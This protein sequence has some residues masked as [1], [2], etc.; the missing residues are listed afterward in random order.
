[1]KMATGMEVGNWQLHHNNTHTHASRLVQG[2]VCVCVCVCETSND[3][4][5]PGPLQPKFGAPSLL[6][7]LKTKITY[8][9]E[10]IS[11]C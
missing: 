10:E 6:A 5:D 7:F 9:R 4:D 8:K 2:C 3:P 11:N 1:M